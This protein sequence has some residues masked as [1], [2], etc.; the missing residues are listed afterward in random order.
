M[1]CIENSPSQPDGSSPN[2]NINSMEFAA[3]FKGKREIYNFL[4]IDVK[5]YLPRYD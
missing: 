3:K 2:P 5:A 1:D 4:T